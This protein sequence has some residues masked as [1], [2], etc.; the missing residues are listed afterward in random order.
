M[1]S[2]RHP[3]GIERSCPQTRLDD[4]RTAKIGE[5]I[6]QCANIEGHAIIYVCWNVNCCG[7]MIP[8]RGCNTTAHTL[9]MNLELC[10]VNKRALIKS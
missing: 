2:T 6:V 5:S 9:V 1:V 3:E 8:L 10:E 4:S 7:E